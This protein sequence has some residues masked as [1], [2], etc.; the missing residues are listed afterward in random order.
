M[1]IIESSRPLLHGRI[2]GPQR[3]NLLSMTAQANLTKALL[4]RL[5]ELK[6]AALSLSTSSCAIVAEQFMRPSPVVY[7]DEVIDF[8]PLTMQ[9]PMVP[10]NETTL[11]YGDSE[12]AKSLFTQRI[13]LS[14]QFGLPLPWSRGV[15]L[16]KTNVLICD[17][18]TNQRVVSERVQR[19]AAGLSVPILHPHIAYRGML[20]R[21]AVSPLRVLEDE[22]PSLREQITR[23]NIGL[24][25]VD[26]IGFAVRGKLIDDD[27]ARGA[28][29]DLRQLGPVT[30][31]VVAH[32][33]KES[34]ARSAGRVDPFGSA[35]F[36]AGVRSAF[37]IRRAEEDIRPDH[38]S[39]GVYH[40]KA[41][42]APHTPPFG[43][44]IDFDGQS[45]PISFSLEDMMGTPD[46]AARTSLSSRLRAQLRTGAQYTPDLARSLEE[47][48]DIV[49]KTLRRMPDAMQLVAGG[50]R[51]NPALWGLR[52]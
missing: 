26:S 33:S 3:V 13:A 44:G 28:I 29:M 27:V 43:V 21:E 46:L 2:F 41:N 15:E 10:I 48:V 1:L 37:E 45:G 39:V 47:D 17:W 34:A 51:N 8:G 42:D 4:G 18:E 7:L 14:A 36:R 16:P 19:L 40:W 31:L 25:I 23:Q 38:I 9:A 11:I 32:I 52:G 35:F 24:V 20:W 22:L 30:R 5:P 49:S 50:G 6:D 12:S